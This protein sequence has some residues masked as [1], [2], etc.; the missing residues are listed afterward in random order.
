M[1]F[2]DPNTNAAEGHGTNAKMAVAVLP[3]AAPN[4]GKGHST[5]AEKA[6][7]IVTD[8]SPHAAEGQDKFADKVDVGMPDAAPVA[9]AGW[10][11]LVVMTKSEVPVSALIDHLAE[12]QVRRKFWSSCINKQTNAAKALVRRAMGWRYDADEGDRAKVNSRAARI[13]AAALAGK[14]QKAEDAAVYQALAADLKAFGHAI[15]PCQRQ[16]H[17]IELDMKRAARKLPIYAW[18]KAIPGLGELGLAIIIA[19]AGDLSGYPKKGHLWKRLGLAPFEGRAFS[20][21]RMKG[22]LSA[23][24]W[25]DAGYS[26]RRRAEIYA[27]ISEPLFRANSAAQGDYR[28]IYDRRRASTAIAHPDWTKAHSHMDGL[29][30]MTKYLLRDAW[31]EWR[32]ASPRL[33]EKA[34]V[35]P[36]AATKTGLPSR[37][38]QHLRSS[39]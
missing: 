35:E 8:P 15:E 37:F 25:A 38:N 39:R 33:P 11:S 21:W 36:P 13:L 28:A 19:E 23:E 20:T 16:R 26:P 22:G 9:E 31:R 18:A 6:G 24:Q 17:E 1:T 14:D 12:L 2:T 3:T 4:D 7:L 10:R 29:R 5:F 27:V 34:D 30:V 32:R